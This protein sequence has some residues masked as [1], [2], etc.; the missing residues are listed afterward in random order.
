[1]SGRLIYTSRAWLISRRVPRVMERM[2]MSVERRQS[3]A[4]EGKPIV[5]KG[6]IEKRLYV[7][8]NWHVNKQHYNW[9]SQAAVS[10]G[11]SGCHR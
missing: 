7:P 3:S 4:P 10:P 5:K 6:K 11:G 8:L 1:M 2:R 9:P